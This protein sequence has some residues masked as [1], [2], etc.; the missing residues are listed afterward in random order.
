MDNKDY[1]L[2][3]P[4]VVKNGLLS[5]SIRQLLKTTILIIAD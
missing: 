5:Q 1:P 4:M 3:M 2:H